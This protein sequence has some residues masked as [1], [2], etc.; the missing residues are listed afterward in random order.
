MSVDGCCSHGTHVTHMLFIIGSFD[1][2][3]GSVLQTLYNRSDCKARFWWGK[4]R[5]RNIEP[6]V[7][8]TRL[9]GVSV[10]EVWL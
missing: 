3:A 9:V 8:A 6:V 1:E 10:S 5:R 2:K 4:L 7:E